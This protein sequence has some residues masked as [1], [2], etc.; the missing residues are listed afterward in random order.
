MMEDFFRK[1]DD[2]GF[3]NTDDVAAYESNRDPSMTSINL[4]KLLPQ[5]YLKVIDGYRDEKRK[6]KLKNVAN[7][8]NLFLKTRF[9]DTGIYNQW[10]ELGTIPNY[11]HKGM[12]SKSLAILAS[13]IIK[14]RSLIEDC[15][16]RMAKLIS[17]SKDNKRKIV[18]LDNI[19]N[20]LQ[21]NIKNLEKYEDDFYYEFVDFESSLGG[22]Y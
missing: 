4:E 9:N 21:L 5:E 20:N 19:Y 22:V 18:S 6:N 13:K 14:V 17:K 11:Y 15:N 2:I 16:Y 12:N 7:N 10:S 1:L 8:I 3:K